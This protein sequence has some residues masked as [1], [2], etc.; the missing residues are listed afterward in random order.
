MMIIW[1]RQSVGHSPWRP[2]PPYTTVR[3]PAVLPPYTVINRPFTLNTPYTDPTPTYSR[4]TLR[5]PTG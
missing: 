5:T 3:T 2:N 4:L 1:H